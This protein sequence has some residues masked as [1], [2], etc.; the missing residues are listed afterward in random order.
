MDVWNTHDGRVIL[1]Y[2]PH[3]YLLSHTTDLLQSMLIS[4][5]RKRS[6]RRQHSVLSPTAS[7]HYQQQ[8]LI[9]PLERTCS[10]QPNQRHPSTCSR[11]WLYRLRRCGTNPWRFREVL[12]PERDRLG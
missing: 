7:T 4:L 12:A 5:F 10:P 1:M 2:A 8:R 3:A 9:R 6:V 11:W